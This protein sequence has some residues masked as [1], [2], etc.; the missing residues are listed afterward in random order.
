MGRATGRTAAVAV[1]GF[2][3]LGGAGLTAGLGFFG[4]FGLGGG[5]GVAATVG[6]GLGFG[7]WGAGFGA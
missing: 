1:G 2:S 3:A 5:G 4:S 7:F 6:A